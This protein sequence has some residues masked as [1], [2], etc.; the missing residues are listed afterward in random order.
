LGLAFWL[1][2]GLG[3]FGAL[4][5]RLVPARLSRIE[6]RGTLPEDAAL[7]REK[8]FDR[9]HREA[10]GRSDLVKTLLENVLLPYARSFFGPLG[11]LLS[12][13]SYKDEEARLLERI[14]ALLQG[15][16]KEKL[17]GID[18]LIRVVVELRAL[19]VRVFYTRVLRAWLAPHL[20]LSA[21][22]IALLAL[23]L[24]AV[25]GR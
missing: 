16:G 3:A 4:V 21:I 7:E 20:V 1:A 23:H 2:C 15:R 25:G 13:R 18:E 6:R 9:L 8:L 19:S 22:A 5:Y 14:H 11:L 12:G 24:Y 10:T 17:T